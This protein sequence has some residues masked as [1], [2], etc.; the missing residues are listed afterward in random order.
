MVKLIAIEAVPRF[1]VF[2]SIFTTK[3]QKLLFCL[4]VF[5]RPQD[6]FPETLSPLLT[7]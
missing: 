4:F 6:F 2:G 5:K 1:G 3:H 7:N